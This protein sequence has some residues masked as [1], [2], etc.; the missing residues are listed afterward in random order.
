MLKSDAKIS[1]TANFSVSPLV[2]MRMH[3]HTLPTNLNITSHSAMKDRILLPLIWKLASIYYTA[4]KRGRKWECRE[5]RLEL[6]A[7]IY[8]YFNYPILVFF[9][10][11]GPISH[12]T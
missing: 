10:F 11:T 4:R 2:V 7:L 3:L 12:R 1:R 6:V 9:N 8:T 5:A